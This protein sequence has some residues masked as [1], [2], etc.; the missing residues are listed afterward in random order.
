MIDLQY[1]DQLNQKVSLAL[2]TGHLG[3]PFTIQNKKKIRLYAKDSSHYFVQLYNLS[4]VFYL[5]H[6]AMSANWPIK[7][8]KYKTR[9]FKDDPSTLKF[10][11]GMTPV[12]NVSC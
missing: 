3:N 10:R 4:D 6:L 2:A 8:I 12:Q 5:Y 7:Q 1:H 11:G 9:I